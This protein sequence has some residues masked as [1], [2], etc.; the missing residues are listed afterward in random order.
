MFYAK[1]CTRYAFI[2]DYYEG[3]LFKFLNIL[4]EVITIILWN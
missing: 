3:V 2:I 1:V 4:V